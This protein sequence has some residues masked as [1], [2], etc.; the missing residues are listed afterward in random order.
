[1]KKRYWNIKFKEM[2]EVGI[3]FG[4]G[5]RNRNKIHGKITHTYNYYYYMRVSIHIL[6]LTR[7]AHFLLEA[8]ELVLHAANKGKNFLIVGKKKKHNSIVSIAKKNRCHYFKKKWL[9]GLLTNWYTIEIKLLNLRNLEVEQK[10]NTAILNK[11]KIFF[12]TFLVGIKYMIRLPDI[13]IIF[14]LQ[15][16]YKI[17]RECTYMGIT[18][19]LL[20]KCNSNTAL[21][22]ILISAN[23]D[24]LASIQLILKKLVFYINEGLNYYYFNNNKI[25]L[26]LS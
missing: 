3:H 24:A 4:H 6:N 25:I 23:E 21:A 17:L 7:T 13:V 26:A 14:G 18:T 2:M 20:K 15:E 22:D 9:G 19:I 16:N 12:Q 10:G 1:M 8:C 5:I 11:L